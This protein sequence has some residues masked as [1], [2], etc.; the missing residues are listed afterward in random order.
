MIRR[1]LVAN[2]GEIACRVLRT[3][4]EMGIESAV[5]YSTAD[6]NAL[7]VRMADAAFAVGPPPSDQ[8]Y[9]NIEAILAAA[10]EWRAD[11]IHPGYGFLSENA[12]FARA[13]EDAGLIFVGPPAHVIADMG[14]KA[15]ARQLMQ[16]ANVPVIPGF[17]SPEG[18]TTDDGQLQQEATAIGYPVLIK[19]V[20]GGGGRGLRVVHR[21]EQFMEALKAVRREASSAFGDASVLLEKYLTGAR[22]IEVQV[23]ADTQGQVIHLHERDCSVQRRHQKLIEEAPA[24]GLSEQLRQQM[25]D[26]AVQAARAIGYVGAGTV[27]FLMRDN[28][29]WFMEMN[30]RLQVEHPVTEAVTGQDLVAWQL[31]IASGEPLPL[32][33]Q[34]VPL[35]GHAMEARL[36]AETPALDFLPSAGR[37]QS[38]RWPIGP[39]LR[40]DTGYMAGDTVSVHYDSLLAKLIVHAPQRNDVIRMMAEVLQQIRVEGTDTNATLLATLVQHPD[41]LSGSMPTTWLEEVLPALLRDTSAATAADRM[42]IREDVPAGPLRAWRNLTHNPFSRRYHLQE[43]PAPG[44]GRDATEA[45]PDRSNR[46]VAPLPGRIVSLQ[47][48]E[49]EAVTAGQTL[50]IMEAMKMEHTLTAPRAATIATL[51]C[52]EGELVAPDTVLLTFAED[53][54]E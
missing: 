27:E 35:Q 34:D 36:N 6:H 41:F 14:S 54:N 9:L 28:E 33:Q 25:G 23:F 51:P 4:Q 44:H 48:A 20:A 30:T 38:I 49:G 29:F 46:I 21:E 11:A 17:Q 1:L 47:V 31:R 10:R 22:H 24:P 13:V 39:G 8:S 43:K 37:L 45:G 26:A 52:S 15:R 32:T 50:L 18:S 40:I 3:A 16:A 42:S 5:V 53:I 7:P 2:R 12:G 19:A